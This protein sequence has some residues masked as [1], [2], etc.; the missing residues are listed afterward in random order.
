MKSIFIISTFVLAVASMTP[1]Y[2]QESAVA[3]TLD[4]TS[5][6]IWRGWDLTPKNKSAVQPGVSYSKGSMAYGYWSS[7]AVSN[8][9]ELGSLDEFDVYFEYSSSFGE[10]TGYSVGLTYY[11]WLNAD[12]FSFDGNTTPEPFITVTDS[13]MPYGLSVGLYYDL[14]LGDGIYV[15]ASGSHSMNFAERAVDFSLSAGYNGGQWGA[16]A[17]ISDIVF[18]ASSSFAFSFGSLSP[19]VYYAIIPL[20]VSGISSEN[21]F[22]FSLGFGR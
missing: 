11:S 2:A 10:T 8:R 16:D 5:K 3:Y 19:A 15:L 4:Y 18:S 21:E 12:D 13:R 14:N 7:L 6:Y 9:D 1:V 20:S 22:W 17:G